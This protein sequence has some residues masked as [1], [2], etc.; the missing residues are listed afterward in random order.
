MRLSKP[1]VDPLD[2]DQWDEKTSEVMKP[3]VDTNSLINIFKTLAHHPALLKR[4]R[5]FGAH[6]MGKSTLDV[7]D[8]EILVLRTCC[9][10]EADYEW[11]PHVAM[12]KRAG[13]TDEEIQGIKEG[14]TTKQFSD[15]E[16]L[17]LQ[18]ADDL[19]ADSIVEN[20]TWQGLTKHYSIQKMM[21]IL[22]TV[23]QYSM[24]SMALNSLGVQPEEGA[25]TLK[26]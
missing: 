7:R 1:R 5:V 19:H 21:D 16:R 26:S 14:P 6:I 12:A 8:R 10:C 4:W 3:Y 2:Q 22:F 9:L 24:I 20:E 23:G 18:A 25:A 11:G 13:F 17:L 15:K